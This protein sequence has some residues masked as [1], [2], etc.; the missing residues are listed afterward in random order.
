MALDGW[1]LDPRTLLMVSAL[2]SASMGG[3]ALSFRNEGRRSRAIRRYGISLLLGSAS[4]LLLFLRGS[5]PDFLTYPFAVWLLLVAMVLALS[6]LHLGF[7]LPLHA[8]GFYGVTVLA[9]V[10]YLYFFY[11]D[12]NHRARTLLFC[13]VTVAVFT[14]YLRMCVQAWPTDRSRPLAVL[15]A[16]SALLLAANV[17]RFA[18]YWFRPPTETSY[19]QASWPNALMHS[20]GIVFTAGGTLAFILTQV[21]RLQN[22]VHLMA[23]RD[24]LTQLLNRRGFVQH[25]APLVNGSVARGEQIALVMFD[26][27]HFKALNDNHGHDTGD[28]LLVEVARIIA[29]NVRRDDLVA[30]MGGEEFVVLMPNITT[31]EALEIAHRVRLALVR[32]N[33]N[34]AEGVPVFCTTSAGIA[35]AEAGSAS[36]ESLYSRADR[37]LYQ[38]KSAGRNRCVVWSTVAQIQTTPPKSVL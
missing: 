38:A 4:W 26:L 7:E 28:K 17:G 15:V 11:V 12:N 33:V 22:E 3:V 16:L 34:D 30:R 21:R 9:F 2:S 37:A 19:L 14:Q 5:L 32:V 6:A 31:D 27:D 18:V 13:V 25:A 29:A 23:E 36:W 10:A 24:E 1:T 8:A 35:L 20:V